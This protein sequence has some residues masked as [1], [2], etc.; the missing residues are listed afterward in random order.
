MTTS[1]VGSRLDTYIDIPIEIGV[2]HFISDDCGHGDTGYEPNFTNFK[3]SL[4][5]VICHRGK[6]LDAGHYIALVR[7]REDRNGQATQWLRFDDLAQQRIA[8]VDIQKALKDECPYLLFYQT[9]PIDDDTFSDRDDPPTYDEATTDSSKVDL[10][11]ASST[12]DSTEPVPTTAVMPIG[13]SE[14]TLTST[15]NTE[16]TPPTRT[17]THAEITTEEL[18]PVVSDPE[19][20]TKTTDPP[21]TRLEVKE[22]ENARPK[23]IDLT[24]LAAPNANNSKQSLEIPRGRSSFQSNR[25]SSVALTASDNETSAKGGSSMPV[26]PGD[27]NRASWMDSSRRNSFTRG[28]LRPRSRPPSQTGENRLSLSMNRLKSAMSKDKLAEHGTKEEQTILF[29]SSM[30]KPH[31]TKMD[32]PRRTKSLRHKKDKGK[33]SS[34]IGKIL[35]RE[36]GTEKSKKAPDRECIIM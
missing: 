6:S 4:L 33:R 12:A 16:S 11:R 28:W 30:E 32:L 27:D 34:S 35:D 13:T 17:T 22:T 8:T 20:H 7:G 10:T 29:E 26:T 1:G 24:G 5:A 9:R 2:P 3:L 21:V 36:N 31:P 14:E 15:T 25:R 23:S 18:T 19:A